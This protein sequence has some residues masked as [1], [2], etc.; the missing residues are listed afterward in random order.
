M[1]LIPQN[2]VGD[3]T[4][5]DNIDYKIEN[6]NIKIHPSKPLEIRFY[7]N[8]N[9]KNPSPKIMEIWMNGL[10]ICNTT[11]PKVIIDVPPKKIQAKPPV[12][13]LF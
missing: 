10:L 4:T 11:A 6:K 3:V 2:W 1:N 5:T 9:Q 7:V 12:Q 13:R 8:Y